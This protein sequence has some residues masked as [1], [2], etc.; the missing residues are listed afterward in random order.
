MDAAVN[1]HAEGDFS[2]SVS[3][4]SNKILIRII[5]RHRCTPSKSFRDDWPQNISV[6][7]VQCVITLNRVIETWK[8]RPSD[9]KDYVRRI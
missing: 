3:T 8:R 4:D 5:K 9:I 2:V 6:A 7:K 1:P